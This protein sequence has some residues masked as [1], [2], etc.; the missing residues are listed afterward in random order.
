MND[1]IIKILILAVSIYLVGK[2]TRLFVVTDFVTAIISALL[3][4][5]VN[6]I[7]RPVLVLLT[8]PITIITLG[9][10]L[11]IINGFSLMIVASLV[12]KFKVKGCLSAAAAAFLISLTNLLLET[13]IS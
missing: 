6:M 8:L 12:P 13:L 5:L 10:F 1:F 4:A 2:I 7:I 11:F 9:L 3:L